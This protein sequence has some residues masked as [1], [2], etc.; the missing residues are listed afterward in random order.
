MVWES[1]ALGARPASCTI[2]FS[3]TMVRP[4][5]AAYIH[6]VTIFYKRRLREEGEGKR[7]QGV[8]NTEMH[9][10]CVRRRLIKTES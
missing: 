6:T 2:T 8:N 1:R 10:L 9:H 4:T 7:Q 3:T 5:P